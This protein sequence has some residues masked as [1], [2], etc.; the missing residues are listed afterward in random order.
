MEVEDP[1][2]GILKKYKDIYQKTHIRTHQDS[3]GSVYDM[4][5]ITE[6]E[7]VSLMKY[8]YKRPEL[9]FIEAVD[10]YSKSKP[11][12]DID[13]GFDAAQWQIFTTT[14]REKKLSAVVM[15]N[16]IELIDNNGL[17]YYHVESTKAHIVFWPKKNYDQ[18]TIHKIFFEKG[19]KFDQNCKISLRMW[20]QYKRLPDGSINK[21]LYYPYLSFRQIPGRQTFGW[22]KVQIKRGQKGE[23]L[24]CLDQKPWKSP[25]ELKKFFPAIDEDE[26]GNEMFERIEFLKCLSIRGCDD[27]HIELPDVMFAP[28]DNKARAYKQA[29]VRAQ[30]F[31]CGVYSEIDYFD[32]YRIFEGITEMLLGLG[33]ISILDRNFKIVEYLNNH[34]CFVAAKGSGGLIVFRERNMVSRTTSFNQLTREQFWRLV[35]NHWVLPFPRMKNGEPL[36]PKVIAQLEK[37]NNLFYIWETSEYRKSFIDMAFLPDYGPLCKEVPEAFQDKLNT[38]TGL[39]FTKE[40]MQFWYERPNARIWAAKFNKY[41]FEIIAD[42]DWHLFGYIM[43]FVNF[44]VKY[45]GRNLQTMLYIYGGQGTGKSLFTSILAKLFG[46]HAY[47]MNTFD[48]I[49]GGG[50]NA[51]LSEA[52]LCICDEFEIKAGGSSTFK[53]RITADIVDKKE[54]FETN[55]P[56]KNCNKYIATGNKTIHELATILKSNEALTRRVV[57]VSIN[58]DFNRLTDKKRVEEGTEF[59]FKKMYMMEEGSEHFNLIS[60]PENGSAAWLWGFFAPENET[61]FGEEALERWEGGRIIPYCSNVSVSNVENTEENIL[62]KYL[63][64]KFSKGDYCLTG[65]PLRNP[66]IEA[67]W[68]SRDTWP[69]YPPRI[70]NP[71]S[72]IKKFG[73]KY[74][75]KDRWGPKDYKDKDGNNYIKDVHLCM[76]IEFTGSAF[77]RYLCLDLVLQEIKDLVEKDLFTVDNPKKV[78]TIQ[79]LK[80]YFKDFTNNHPITLNIPNAIIDR[81]EKACDSGEIDLESM[82]KEN[83]AKEY[84]KKGAKMSKEEKIYTFL[85]VGGLKNFK[86]KLPKDKGKKLKNF[87]D[88]LVRTRKVLSKEQIDEEKA[89]DDNV[90]EKIYGLQYIKKF[91]DF[92]K[93]TKVLETPPITP[94]ITETEEDKENIPPHV[95]FGSKECDEMA[96]A[97]NETLEYAMEDEDKEN[98]PPALDL[99]PKTPNLLEML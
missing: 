62:L 29:E 47:L 85:D 57:S 19:L 28:T 44:C 11:F 78:L 73:K 36:Q 97:Q 89:N 72:H 45:P 3:W 49:L 98:T 50:F 54:K 17:V 35:K 63:D 46:K 76:S 27:P 79:N 95:I 8:L 25:Q 6:E 5:D 2:D 82:P 68:P 67:Y 61:L 37:A 84:A 92:Y 88:I 30:R 7:W 53:S 26:Q 20:G 66:L 94:E 55:K 23:F 34:I 70:K 21:A 33:P 52:V 90:M 99:E 4:R 10:A 15:L 14:C 16:F 41:I 80:T 13:D 75:L 64:F 42:S 24:Q 69:N 56:V 59:M 81:M 9:C 40:S 96:R 1:V 43:Q 74:T 12:I 39:A 18:P 87:K 48:E 77:Q 91:Y 32:S 22:F 71:L 38:Y 51:H 60:D 86:E 93:P 58:K 83:E 65:N 31:I